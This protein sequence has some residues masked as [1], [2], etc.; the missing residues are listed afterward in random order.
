MGDVEF[1]D[2]LGVATESQ[3]FDSHSVWFLRRMRS[4][5][6]SF[7][8]KATFTTIIQAPSIRQALCKPCC[9]PRARHPAFPPKW[10][11]RPTVVVGR[12]ACL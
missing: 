4:L 8:A 6:F 10:L 11:C 5:E 1:G 12:F 2:Y 9:L 3:L 7:S